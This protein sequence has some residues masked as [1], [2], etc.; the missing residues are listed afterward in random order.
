MCL[1]VAKISTS[2]EETLKF[3]KAEVRDETQE[4]TQPMILLFGRSGSGKTSTVFGRE[5]CE[6]PGLARSWFPAGT[7]IEMRMMEFKNGYFLDLVQRWAHGDFV[8]SKERISNLTWTSLDNIIHI[9]KFQSRIATANNWQSSRGFIW[10]ELRNKDITPSRKIIIIDM[11]GT[12]NAVAHDWQE[13]DDIKQ[14]LRINSQFIMTN[15]KRFTEIIRNAYN[16]L[17]EKSIFQPLVDRVQSRTRFENIFLIV[18]AASPLTYGNSNEVISFLS[19]LSAVLDPSY[20][21]GDSRSPIVPSLKLSPRPGGQQRLQS[22]PLPEQLHQEM[23]R[24]KEE[25]QAAQFKIVEQEALFVKREAL[26]VKQNVF[27]FEENARL[28]K[29]LTE[30]AEQITEQTRITNE[31]V[32][33]YHQINKGLVAVNRSDEELKQAKEQE[34]IDEKIRINDLQ[35]VE[36]TNLDHEGNDDNNGAD[37]N[38]NDDGNDNDNDAGGN[39]DDNDNDNNENDAGGNNDNEA[40]RDGDGD[41]GEGYIDNYDWEAEYSNPDNMAVGIMGLKVPA[42]PCNGKYYQ[43][44]NKVRFSAIQWENIIQNLGAGRHHCSQ[45]NVN[46]KTCNIKHHVWI[47]HFGGGFF[48]NKC[49]LRH[50]QLPAV[51]KHEKK[52]K[53]QV[54][55]CPKCAEKFGST[56]YALQHHRK[57][58]PDLPVPKALNKQRRRHR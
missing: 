34:L 55:T 22:S 6:F 41:D 30:L 19:N 49:K 33:T 24:L 47:H 21:P 43:V 54:H 7:N 50:S 28:N 12:E 27:L 1:T 46:E 32:Q 36:Q 20:R 13:D 16:T 48:C 31:L 17:G 5:G 56:Y 4:E 53:G 38:N 58:T 52:C 15:L 23:E 2:P 3:L 10:L 25:L 11:P 44:Y 57:C 18:C 9:E 26:L 39:N 8:G 51:V 40:E 42:M 35:T 29:Q 14:I 37:G 45:C